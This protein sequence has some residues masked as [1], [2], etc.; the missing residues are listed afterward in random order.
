[1]SLEERNAKSMLEVDIAVA[2]L[3]ISQYDKKKIEEFRNSI[4]FRDKE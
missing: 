4:G 1:M 2:E 3:D